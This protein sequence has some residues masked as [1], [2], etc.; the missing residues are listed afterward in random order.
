MPQNIHIDN[1]RNTPEQTLIEDLIIES[2]EFNGHDIYWLPRKVSAGQYD[3]IYG[4]DPGKFFDEAH[5]LTMYVA[6][7]EGWGG[8]RDVV[9]RFGLEIREQLTLVVA[10]RSVNELLNAT[11]HLKAALSRPREGD[12]LYLDF[13]IPDTE[14]GHAS[15]TLLEINFTEHE[16]IFYQLGELQVYELRCETFRYANE[17]FS[18]GII[19]IDQAVANNY[20]EH[21]HTGNT[22]P[23]GVTADNTLIEDEADDYLDT[24]EDSPFGDWS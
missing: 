17:E 21:V 14:V 22:M 11:P 10:I 9:S 24:S 12:L 3:Q 15:G 7:A 18:T 2:I 4:E 16:S 23:S 19:D 20:S 8:E 1:Y 6:S 5:L 13:G